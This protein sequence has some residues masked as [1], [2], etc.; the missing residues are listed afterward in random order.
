L[1]L[2]LL[3]LPVIAVLLMGR[4]AHIVLPRVRNWMNQHSWIVSEVVLVIFLAIG[5]NSVA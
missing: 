1:T 4:R 3:A 5:I 2:L